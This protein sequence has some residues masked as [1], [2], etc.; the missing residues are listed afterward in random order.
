MQVGT[1]T[2]VTVQQ[3]NCYVIRELASRTPPSGK[4]LDALGPSFL[5]DARSNVVPFRDRPREIDYI[6]EWLNDTDIATSIL[7]IHGPGGAGKTRLASQIATLAAA[8]GWAINEAVE[9]A[10]SQHSGQSNGKAG[11]D[12]PASTLTIVDYADRWFQSSLK[13]LLKDTLSAVGT[14]RI[15]LI[16]RAPAFWKHIRKDLP[17]LAVRLNPF[18][19]SLFEDSD[20]K[21]LASGFRE[22]AVAFAERLG[23]EVSERKI[24]SRIRRGFRVKTLL[25]LHMEALAHVWATSSESDIPLTDDLSAY[26]IDHERRTWGDDASDHIEQIT[27]FATLMGP[28]NDVD[29]AR[30]LIQQAALAGDKADADLLLVRHERLYPQYSDAEVVVENLQPLRPD[31]LGEDFVGS[32]L[33]DPR[34]RRRVLDVINSA[35]DDAQIPLRQCLTVLA[36]ASERHQG[37]WETLWSVLDTR[38]DLI[39]IAPADVL[40]LLAGR[41]TGAHAQVVLEHLP[42][43][44]DERC[45][46]AARLAVVAATATETSGTLKAHCIAL[47]SA[48]NRLSVAGKATEAADQAHAA[49]SVLRARIA[50]GDRAAVPVLSALLRAEATEMWKCGR[51]VPALEPASESTYLLKQLHTRDPRAWAVEYATSLW[52]LGIMFADEAEDYPRGLSLT[53]QAVDI[54]REH[55]TS[56]FDIEYERS[57]ALALH[58]LG[59][60]LHEAAEYDR[61]YDAFDECCS[62]MRKLVADSPE[63]HSGPL[64]RSLGQFVNSL[65]WRHQYADAVEVA[66]EAVDI[67]RRHARVA[68]PGRVKDLA[69]SLRS[70]GIAYFANRQI[71]EAELVLVEA[72]D[73]FSAVVSA[74]SSHHMELDRT[75]KILS[76]VRGGEE[77]DHAANYSGVPVFDAS[78]VPHGVAEIAPPDSAARVLE[79]IENA[80]TAHRSGLLDEAT[81]QLGLAA[82]HMVRIGPKHYVTL[83]YS[84]IS[85]A[86]E[87]ADLCMSD[88][89]TERSIALL[90]EAMSMAEHRRSDVDLIAIEYF[91]VGF[92][93][94]A[95][96]ELVGRYGEALSCMRSALE[97]GRALVVGRSSAHRY[98]RLPSLARGLIFSAE[99]LEQ[100]DRTPE[101]VS[102][103]AEAVEM[104]REVMRYHQ[105]LDNADEH[106]RAL[107]LGLLLLANA[108]RDSGGH[109]AALLV[110]AEALRNCEQLPISSNVSYAYLFARTLCGHAR[111]L[112]MGGQADEALRTAEAAMKW[113]RKKPVN[114]HDVRTAHALREDCAQVLA[115]ARGV[116]QGG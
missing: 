109:H 51:G 106:R 77:F 70:L 47:V 13:T 61:S 31:R 18:A 89:D 85:A 112:G 50:G 54:L 6:L 12:Y 14:Q 87:L 10:E 21:E 36:A 53:Q 114:D 25:D 73:G 22:A 65:I 57:L 38:R 7:V 55:R 17:P 68:T 111:L 79:L 83:D 94:A 80:A 92:R 90:G 115:V 62:R 2:S 34:T 95:C 93:R 5:L 42:L 82:D 76:K 102:T 97:V 48:V 78:L 59:V 35:P 116:R 9:A 26:L 43:V 15:L 28:T 33:E 29:Y 91:D 49:V 101:A 100:L 41:L 71:H 3:A 44:A 1:Y 11:V 19:L 16:A 46:A 60:R 86:R 67:S 8:A 103:L 96:L 63:L 30:Q 20:K 56:G 99:I 88:G 69:S 23:V 37:A 27:L 24:K 32:C 81:R 58:N 108:M 113:S 104:S 4:E 64:S 74:T 110:S 72:R 66:G 84:W 107:A 39:S 105:F 75:E 40:T 98:R 52:T 45:E